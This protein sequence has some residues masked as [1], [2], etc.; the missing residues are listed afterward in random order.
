MLPD[1]NFEMRHETIEAVLRKL[2]M[3]ETAEPLLACIQRDIVSIRTSPQKHNYLYGILDI[4]WRPGV[5][6]GSAPTYS[7]C[8]GK[9]PIAALYALRASGCDLQ[10]PSYPIPLG[11]LRQ[12]IC[13]G[14][15]VQ[16]TQS[17]ACPKTAR[18]NPEVIITSL[19]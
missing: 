2:P 3:H 17:Y 8:G 18:A 10:T 15:I 12:E 13:F 5:A 7:V 16:I 1:F 9:S 4:R 11:I 14:A 19:I 6:R